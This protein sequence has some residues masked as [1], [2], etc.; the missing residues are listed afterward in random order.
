MYLLSAVDSAPD[1]A[2][3]LLDVVMLNATQANAG[4]ARAHGVSTGAPTFDPWC[5]P[6]ESAQGDVDADPDGVSHQAVV[7][8]ITLAAWGKPKPARIVALI[9]TLS[10]VKYTL[11]SAS[12]VAPSRTMR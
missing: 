1:H 3:V 6:C 11:R 8:L 12:T 4:G 10:L 2:S 9:A 5:A 7:T